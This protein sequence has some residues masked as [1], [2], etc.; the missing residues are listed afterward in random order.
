MPSSTCSCLAQHLSIQSFPAISS[1]VSGKGTRAIDAGSSGPKGKP[2]TKVAISESGG[3]QS[4]WV[5][6]FCAGWFKVNW[7]QAGVTWE[8]RIS[9]KQMSPQ[10]IWPVGKVGRAF[11]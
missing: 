9:A 1:F 7:T 3:R 2:K 11:S 8:E 4:A 10:D 5:A 6:G